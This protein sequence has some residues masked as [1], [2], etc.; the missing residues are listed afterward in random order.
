VSILSLQV[1][2]AYRDRAVYEGDPRSIDDLSTINP[3]ILAKA[4]YL[5][6]WQGKYDYL[7]VLLPMRDPEG[8]ASLLEWGELLESSDIAALYRIRHGS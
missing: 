3:R 4:P 7:L 2:P 8:V 1:R 5:R 6:N